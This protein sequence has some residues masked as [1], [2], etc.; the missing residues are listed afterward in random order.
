MNTIKKFQTVA[1]ITTGAA[2][3]YYFLNEQQHSNKS[4]ATAENETRRQGHTLKG[5]LVDR[6]KQV[7]T[8][9]LTSQSNILDSAKR[10]AR[11][12]FSLRSPIKLVMLTMIRRYPVRF[13]LSA[14]GAD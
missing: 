12:E 14:I 2:I 4:L 1:L 9:R 3:G 10:L 11:T 7:I 6:D 8:D 13:G 5:D